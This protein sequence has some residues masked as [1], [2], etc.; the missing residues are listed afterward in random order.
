MY[1]RICYYYKQDTNL[2]II[3]STFADAPYSGARIETPFRNAAMRERRDAP[4]SGARIETFAIDSLSPYN[5]DAPYSGARI[6]T[7]VLQST[8]R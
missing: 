1:V 4:Y 6:E 8:K 2:M 7:V 3:L 5:R